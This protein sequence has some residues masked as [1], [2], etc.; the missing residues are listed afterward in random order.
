MGFDCALTASWKL[1]FPS[2]VDWPALKFIVLSNTKYEFDVVSKFHDPLSHEPWLT[3]TSWSG[4]IMWSVLQY[5]S[6]V[7]WCDDGEKR[8]LLYQY[9][10]GAGPPH[11][12]QRYCTQIKMWCDVWR[13]ADGRTDGQKE[14]KAVWCLVLTWP[15][16]DCQGKISLCPSQQIFETG[17]E[18]PELED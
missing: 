18:G 15:K 14:I 10:S 11:R 6:G 2:E 12:D 5:S 9:C 16:S 4:A 3:L 1:P 17:P 8:V 7:I 13:M